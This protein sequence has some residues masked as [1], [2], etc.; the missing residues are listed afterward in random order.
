MTYEAQRS[1]TFPAGCHWSKG[2]VRELTVK[3][4]APAWLVPVPEPKKPAKAK[5][6]KTG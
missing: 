1:G 6:K 5:P 2:E 4:D 3:G